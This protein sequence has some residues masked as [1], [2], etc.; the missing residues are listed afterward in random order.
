ML[1]WCFA[2]LWHSSPERCEWLVSLVSAKACVGL[3][4]PQLVVFVWKG[5]ASLWVETGRWPNWG[6]NKDALLHLSCLWFHNLNGNSYRKQSWI[7][8]LAGRKT[9]TKTEFYITATTIC[10]ISKIFSFAC[11]FLA[12]H[13][14]ILPS[15]PAQ[16]VSKMVLICNLFSKWCIKL[17]ILLL[18]LLS[19]SL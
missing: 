1:K 5:R 15:L 11:T 8:L 19:F 7:C 6:G 17:T 2:A 18:F 16:M 13:L 10:H 12:A 3:L 14:L 4:S 9:C